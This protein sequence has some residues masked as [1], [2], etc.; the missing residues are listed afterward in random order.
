MIRP[1]GMADSA[2]P[3]NSFLAFAFGAKQWYERYHGY[4]IQSKLLK[5]LAANCRVLYPPLGVIV[6]L[7]NSVAPIVTFRLLAYVIGVSRTSLLHIQN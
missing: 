3:K 2:T 5:H 6:Q 4:K 7:A 1:E